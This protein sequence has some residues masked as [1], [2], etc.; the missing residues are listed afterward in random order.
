MW[1]DVSAFLQ[2]EMD[3]GFNCPVEAGGG[4]DGARTPNGDDEGKSEEDGDAGVL[5]YRLRVGYSP[6]PVSVC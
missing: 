4:Y 5:S 3:E 2:A 6:L 1:L